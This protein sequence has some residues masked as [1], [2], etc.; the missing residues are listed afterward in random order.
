MVDGVRYQLEKM[1][2]KELLS[3]YNVDRDPGYWPET[4]REGKCILFV[5]VSE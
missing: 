3:R 2:A 5:S 1:K 4:D